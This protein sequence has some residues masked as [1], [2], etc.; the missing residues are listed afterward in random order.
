M[1]LTEIIV[2]NIGEKE[3]LLYPIYK[4]TLKTICDDSEP[5][6]PDQSLSDKIYHNRYSFCNF[7]TFYFNQ[8]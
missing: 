3:E 5:Y 1:L 8:K 2:N 6:M 4:Y 7:N